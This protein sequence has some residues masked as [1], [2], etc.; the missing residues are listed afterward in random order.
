MGKVRL[1]VPLLRQRNPMGH[2]QVIHIQMQK[3][4]GPQKVLLGEIVIATVVV[5][6]GVA[7]LQIVVEQKD[8]VMDGV[9][10]MHIKQELVIQNLKHLVQVPLLQQVIV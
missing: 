10:L 5:V 9:V 1:R 8:L 6:G 4:A 3:V 7:V 2:Q